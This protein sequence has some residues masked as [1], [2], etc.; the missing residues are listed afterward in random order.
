MLNNFYLDGHEHHYESDHY[1]FKLGKPIDAKVMNAIYFCSTEEYMKV[2]IAAKLKSKSQNE[3]SGNHQPMGFK[4]FNLLISVKIT[5]F[6]W[7]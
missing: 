2:A 5:I 1:I 4:Y 6:N 3:Y 7:T